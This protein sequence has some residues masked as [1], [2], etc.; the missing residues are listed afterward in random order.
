MTVA[1]A[2]QDQRSRRPFLAG[3]ISQVLQ[4]YVLHIVLIGL[5]VGWMLPTI[6]L[7]A[8]RS[9]LSL[10][11]TSGWWTALSPFEFTVQKLHGRAR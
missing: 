1:S 10:T 4:R 3:W 2:A 6:G 9:G 7:L 11:K 5:T 8:A